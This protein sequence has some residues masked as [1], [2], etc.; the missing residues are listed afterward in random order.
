M[1]VQANPPGAAA[2]ADMAEAWPN[3]ERLEIESMCDKG[4]AV[5]AHNMPN[6]VA[7]RLG[8][9]DMQDRWLMALSQTCR[10]LRV[11]DLRTPGP[12]E[13][14]SDEGLV[15]IAMGCPELKD[16]NLSMCDCRLIT[17]LTYDALA[18][19]S[20]ELR[21][22]SLPE[23]RFMHPGSALTA[24][25]L[26]C[27]KLTRLHMTVNRSHGV[28][29]ELAIPQWGTRRGFLQLRCLGLSLC[30]GLRDPDLVTLAMSFPGLET[31]RLSNLRSCHDGALQALGRGCPDLRSVDLQDARLIS[32]A[33]VRALMDECAG[34]ERVAL[35]F[36]GVSDRL[37]LALARDAT[38]APRLQ[39]LD[40]LGTFAEA[41]VDGPPL[42]E[43]VSAE[44][45]RRLASVRPELKLRW[46]AGG[47]AEDAIKGGA[48]GHYATSHWPIPQEEISDRW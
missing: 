35:E 15:E 43:P 33:G 31:L 13:L 24:L 21:A 48:A 6:L 3:L 9:E 1:P 29:R 12:L 23:P 36:V 39:I 16:L 2:A 17:R 25:L 42:E 27:S 46:R 18:A 11:L 47:T 40:V 19:H 10:R 5:I 44:G 4:V 41:S 28:L 26:G 8:K 14:V 34:I 30:M 7:L 38:V 22:L 45:V 32:D 20:R 37:M